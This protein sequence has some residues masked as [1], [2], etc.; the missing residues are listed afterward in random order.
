MALGK[1]RTEPGGTEPGGA[2]PGTSEYGAALQGVP[3]PPLAV[4]VQ[5]WYAGLR[6]TAGEAASAVRLVVVLALAGVPLGLLWWAVAPRR[7][8]EV[9]EQGAFAIVPESEAAVGSDGWLM[10]LTG[11]LALVATAL[12]WR[13]Q[14]H[15]GPLVP[16]GLALGMLL[17]GL[18]TWQV[19][20]LLGQGPSAAALAEIGSIV[21]GPV[22]LRAY[23][24][25]VVAPFLAVAG[26]LF[27]VCFTP[28]DDLRTVEPPADQAPSSVG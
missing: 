19:G 21:L 20:A 23:G 17:C 5:R 28:R 27:A 7:A 22:E 14:A 12:A 15:R 10:V 13:R 9:A 8:Y 25:L 2:E 26:Y 16:V 1:H 18:L 4:P 6:P 3:P 24:V 11:V